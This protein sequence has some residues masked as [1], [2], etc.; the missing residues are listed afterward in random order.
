MGMVAFELAEPFQR[1]L[2][3]AVDALLRDDIVLVVAGLQLVHRAVTVLELHDVGGGNIAKDIPVII[4]GAFIPRIER[5]AHHPFHIDSTLL[6][7]FVEQNCA[8]LLFWVWFQ[9]TNKLVV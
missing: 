8:V 1:I 3:S 6:H 9:E 4:R 7:D 5:E 2:V